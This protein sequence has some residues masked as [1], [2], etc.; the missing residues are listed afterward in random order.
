MT[1][2]FRRAPTEAVMADDQKE[3]RAVQLA[4]EALRLVAAGDDEVRLRLHKA[5]YT[6]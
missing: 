2:T 1:T 4:S 6:C 3:A 5:D